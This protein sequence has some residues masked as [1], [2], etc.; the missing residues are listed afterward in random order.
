MTTHSVS[1]GAMLATVRRSEMSQDR[2]TDDVSETAPAET[3]ITLAE[4]IATIAWVWIVPYLMGLLTGSVL[5]MSHL[6][7]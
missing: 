1:L 2:L 7:Y 4:A 5:A 3:R 6:T